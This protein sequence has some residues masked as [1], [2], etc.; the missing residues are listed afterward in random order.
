[1]TDGVR[2]EWPDRWIHV[3]GSHTEPVIRVIAEAPSDL[4]AR[5]MVRR[6]LEYLRPNLPT[7]GE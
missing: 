2:I 7:Y 5:S 4:V 1:M 6:A 3:R